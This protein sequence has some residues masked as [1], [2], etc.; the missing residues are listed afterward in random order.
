MPGTTWTL[1]DLWVVVVPHGRAGDPFPQ[2]RKKSEELRAFLEEQDAQ[3]QSALRRRE[4][5]QQMAKDMR[6]RKVGTL[7]PICLGQ[8]GLSLLAYMH[9]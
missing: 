1:V 3:R 7:P 4:Q 6:R 5:E 2:D 9:T 8:H